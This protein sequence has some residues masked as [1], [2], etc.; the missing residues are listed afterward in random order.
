MSEETTE[1]QFVAEDVDDLRTLLERA[2]GWAERDV[3]A[4]VIAAEIRT[5]LDVVD[6]LD[7]G[8]TEA[9]ADD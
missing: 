7:G 3:G 8:R 2:A 6:E 1:P 5:G 9:V 4:E